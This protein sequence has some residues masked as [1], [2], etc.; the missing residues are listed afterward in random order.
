MN[1]LVL[2]ARV[3]GIA[4]AQELVSAF[5]HAAFSNEER[6]L[7]RLGKVQAIEERHS[8]IRQSSTA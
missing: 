8:A 4:M 6:H 7:R 3:I 2:G 1:I 5:V